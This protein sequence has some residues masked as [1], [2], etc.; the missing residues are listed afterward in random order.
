VARSEVLTMNCTM[1]MAA[2]QQASNGHVT[3]NHWNGIHDH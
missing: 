3:S 2:P 1:P